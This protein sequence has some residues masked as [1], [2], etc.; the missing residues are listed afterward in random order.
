MA[1]LI[2]FHINQDSSGVYKIH[3]D[4]LGSVNFK[5]ITSLHA[6]VPPHIMQVNFNQ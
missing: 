1:G 5:S 3:L 2:K 4:T 6:E